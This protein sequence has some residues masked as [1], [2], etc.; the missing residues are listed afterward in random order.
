MAREVGAQWKGV[1]AAA[2]SAGP[3]LA[4]GKAG[5]GQPKVFLTCS[6][7]SHFPL[8]ADATS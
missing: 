6:E 3:R 1:G 8:A 7:G 2:R 5:E 4:V